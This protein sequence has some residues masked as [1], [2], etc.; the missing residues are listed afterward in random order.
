MQGFHRDPSA[1][2]S[3]RLVHKGDQDD[4]AVEGVDRYP[5]TFPASKNHAQ[6][7]SGSNLVKYTADKTFHLNHNKKINKP[8]P[9]NY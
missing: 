5:Y 4:D 9:S 7:R 1:F 8:P 3:Q 2:L 6:R